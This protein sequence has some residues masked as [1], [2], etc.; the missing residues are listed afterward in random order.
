[1][2][3]RLHDFMTSRLHDSMT[4]RVFLGYSR[5]VQPVDTVFLDAGGVLV[6][7]NWERASQ[8][9]AR[10][11]VIV[12]PSELADAE[13]RAKRQMDVAPTIGATNDERRGWLYFDLVLTQ[14]GVALSDATRAALADLRAYHA[15]HNLWE[16]TPPDVVP[17]LARLRALGVR[18]VVV[19]NS[20]GT[21]RRLFDRL[22]LTPLVDVVLDSLDE[23][24]E[25][26][27]PRFFRIALARA[28]ARAETTVHVG[29]LFHVDVEGARSA[30]LR[31]VLVDPAG[32]YDGC[33]CT[34]VASIG[35]FVDRLA[36]GALGPIPATRHGGAAS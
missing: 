29:D 33:D 11:G 35:A 6:F 22:G 20:N 8:A 24:V 12:S 3:S 28:G 5:A 16:T 36:A 25:K 17:A 4:S 1:M 34:R 32:L 30:G 13:P 15:R 10:H 23:G 27:D 14:A 7:P 26:P 21:L 9:L 19:S 18:V 31:A 2:T